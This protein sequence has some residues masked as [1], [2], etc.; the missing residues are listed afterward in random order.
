MRHSDITGTIQYYYPMRDQYNQ[1][2]ILNNNQVMRDKK[3]NFQKIDANGFRKFKFF[4]NR[5]VKN[6]ISRVLKI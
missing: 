6:G 4:R 3:E 2:K 5:V 1:F